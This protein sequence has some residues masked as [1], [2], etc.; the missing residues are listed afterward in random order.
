MITM[1][2][3]KVKV[4]VRAGANAGERTLSFH[5]PKE[6]QQTEWITHG[7]AIDGNSVTTSVTA[8]TGVAELPEAIPGFENLPAHLRVEGR[9]NVRRL[10][11]H[12][13][14]TLRTLPQALQEV[15]AWL[16]EW[17]GELG[18]DAEFV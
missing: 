10:S 16:V 15:E 18:Y 9:R 17:L 1:D 13:R 8:L 7:L 2:R 12:P 11:T 14:G 6:V 4:Y 3:Q 5:P